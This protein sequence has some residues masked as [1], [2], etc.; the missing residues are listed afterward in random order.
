MISENSSPIDLFY[1]D[2]RQTRP[3]FKSDACLPMTTAEVERRGWEEV[4]VIIV[5]GDAYVDSPNFS[6]GRIARILEKD[7]FS[8]AIIS[9]PQWDSVHDFQIFGRPRLAFYVT[10][11]DNDSMLN[12]YSSNRSRKNFDRYTAGGK[13]DQRPDRATIQYCQRAKEAFPDVL[14]SLAG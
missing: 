5:T 8:V 10:A 4:D 1:D 9:Q 14:S 6:N 3:Q 7:G 2:R 11:G 12:H 13:A